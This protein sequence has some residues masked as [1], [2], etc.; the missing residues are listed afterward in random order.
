MVRDPTRCRSGGR[1]ASAYGCGGELSPVPLLPS[2]PSTAD[3]ASLGDVEAWVARHLGDLTL[4]GPDG[5]R[6][7]G[8]DGGQDAADAALATLDIDGYAR[9]RST[10]LPAERRGSS[11]LSPYI[12]Y[13]LLPLPRVWAAVADAPSFDRKRFRDE[14]LWQEFARHLYSR[15]GPR[16]TSSLRNAGPTQGRADLGPAGLGPLDGVPG[17]RRGR[18]PRRGLGGQPDPDVA[19]L[20]V[21]RPRRGRLVGGRAGDVRPPA[22]RVPGG[23]RPGL[24]VDDR[25]RQHQGVRVQPLAGAEAGPAALP[26]LPAAR[27]LPDRGLARGAP[28]AGDRPGR[29]EPRADPRRARRRSRARAARWSG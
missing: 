20:A 29:P 8:F 11:R 23:Q 25:H 22:R 18:A 5:V 1:R 24:A 9:T 6:A 10:V 13:G 7:G 2:P 28:A 15:L 14:L 12:R 16:L 4:E 21:V 27:R 19:R 17:L 3:G 26:A